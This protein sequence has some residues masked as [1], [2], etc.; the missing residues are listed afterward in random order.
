MASAAE[1]K[2]FAVLLAVA[3]ITCVKLA[4]EGKA[5]RLS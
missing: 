3:A 5:S 2:S 1:W 4:S